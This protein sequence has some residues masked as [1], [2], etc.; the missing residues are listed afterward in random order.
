MFRT[1]RG[2]D[3][4]DFPVE[5]LLLLDQELLERSFKFWTDPRDPVDVRHG[6]VHEVLVES[7]DHE[8]FLGK[9]SKPLNNKHVNF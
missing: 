8:Q 7:R 4:A 5:L 3:D 6:S 2:V 9:N 1:H